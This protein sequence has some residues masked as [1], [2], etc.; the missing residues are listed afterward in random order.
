MLKTMTIRLADGA[1]WEFVGP[2]A[3]TAKGPTAQAKRLSL[4]RAIA[5]AQDDS[6]RRLG[7][8]AL[9]IFLLGIDRDLGPDDFRQLLTFP[10]D[11]PGAEKLQDDLRAL[12]Q[13]HAETA[14]KRGEPRPAPALSRAGLQVPSR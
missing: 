3:F 8:L 1:D 4:L 5:E 11:G 14:A 10:P 2:E 13:L 7:E 12:A 9:A 6:E